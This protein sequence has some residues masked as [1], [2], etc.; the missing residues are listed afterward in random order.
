MV[1]CKLTLSLDRIKCSTFTISCLIIRVLFPSC[2]IMSLLLNF[3]LFILKLIPSFITSFVIFHLI[4][5]CFSDLKKWVHFCLYCT[6]AFQRHGKLA[7]LC[8]IRLTYK[9]FLTCLALELFKQL[10]T[11]DMTC[12]DHGTKENDEFIEMGR[13]HWSDTLCYNFLNWRYIY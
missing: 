10:T 3:M 8:D 7:I 1:I 2:L 11:L 13:I 5:Q 9:Y 6:S 12:A 4:H